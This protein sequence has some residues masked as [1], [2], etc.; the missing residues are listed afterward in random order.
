MGKRIPLVAFFYP[1]CFWVGDVCPFMLL[2]YPPSFR[3][4]EK[5]EGEKKRKKG[6]ER[7][8]DKGNKRGKERNGKKRIIKKLACK[9]YTQK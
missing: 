1:E 8:R 2:A 7:E 6:S 4:G 5:K 3:K 9:S